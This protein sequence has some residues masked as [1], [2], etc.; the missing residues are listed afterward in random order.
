MPL[1]VVNED[2]VGNLALPI[3][4][5]G[6]NLGF[7][8]IGDAGMGGFWT[9]QN[10]AHAT[11][12]VTEGAGPCQIIVVH[13]T[14]G[15][16]ALGHYAAHW[17]PA[18]ILQGL[19]TMLNA[20]PGAMVDTILFAAGNIGAQHEQLMYEMR[21]V[22]RARQMAPGARVIWPAQRPDDNWGAAMYLPLTGQVAL[23]HSFPHS[24]VGRT[25]AG[26]GLAPHNY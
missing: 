24:I 16:G 2:Q 11:A 17:D 5:Q 15:H 3:F 25:G 14:N 20:L 8:Y 12:L 4:W 6:F 19:Q 23:F 10:P 9:S 7:P 26:N 21:I 13:C 22:A 1:A 18:M